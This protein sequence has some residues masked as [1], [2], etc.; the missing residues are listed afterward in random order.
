MSTNIYRVQLFS[1]T[2]RILHA[3]I[4]AGVIFELISAWLVQHADVDV[5]AWSEWH[6]MIGQA[7]ALPLLLRLYLFIAKGSANWHFFIPTR[8][9]RHLLLQTLKFYASLGRLPCPDWY[10]YNPVWQ[11][12]YLIMIAL[13][14]VTTITGYAL[15]LAPAVYGWHSILAK[16]VLYFT[17]AHIF[18]S[19]LHDVKGNGAQISAM[20]NGYKYFHS[21]D[22]P[23]SEKEN[24]VTL[25]SL[26]KK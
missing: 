6:T 5:I 1:T 10:A 23:H 12:V 18:F 24:A 14:V 4:A 2:Q 22:V 16:G 25:D 21:K 11:P 3:L 13:L 9:Q 7:L 19:I 15:G 26:L 8:E 17:I 20:L